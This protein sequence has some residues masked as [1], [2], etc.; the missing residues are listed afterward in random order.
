MM[1]SWQERSA[2]WTQNRLIGLLVSVRCL[3]KHP[4]RDISRLN[5]REEMT[6]SFKV[7]RDRKKPRV[8][9]YSAMGSVTVSQLFCA[10]HHGEDRS[11]ARLLPAHCRRPGEWRERL[12]DRQ[13]WSVAFRAAMRDLCRHRGVY[14]S[15]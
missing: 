11:P 2:V 15:Q 1:I 4:Q 9:P 12:A 5:L 7:A 13:E 3:R 14:A 8:S 6:I 10:S